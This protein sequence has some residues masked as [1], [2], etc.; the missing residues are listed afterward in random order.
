MIS[1]KD[2][3]SYAIMVLKAAKVV[4]QGYVKDVAQA[5]LIDYAINGI[6]KGLER[7]DALRA[8]GASSTASR[9]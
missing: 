1:E 3:D 8:Q 2:A 7:K 6:F 4:R 9:A 5:T